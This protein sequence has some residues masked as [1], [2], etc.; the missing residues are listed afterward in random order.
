MAKTKH[1]S[2][3]L[4]FEKVWLMFQ[5][6]DKKFQA[7]D[8]KFQTTAKEF[9]E[10]KEL[11]AKSSLE[12]DKSIK[13]LG[14]QIGGL[15]NK[16]GLYNE[17]LFSPSVKHILLTEFKCL[18]TTPN[19][20]FHINGD[21]FEIDYVGFSKDSCYLV[22]IKSHLDLRSIQQLKSI[23][24]NFRKYKPEYKNKKV[25]GIITATQ[26]RKETYQKAIREGFYVIIAKDDL[27]ELSVPVDFKP[28]IW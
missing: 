2:E 10:T 16:I 22:E 7:T 11:L 12:T 18:D 3:K 8:K 14:K 28:K 6:T 20:E 25:Y 1:D 15:G 26:F 19:H 4:D 9:Q 23:I 13:E 5:E 17:G 27:A 21:T 24:K